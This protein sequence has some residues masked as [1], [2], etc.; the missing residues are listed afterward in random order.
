MQRHHTS[1]QV[2]QFVVDEIQLT[3]GSSDATTVTYDGDNVNILS[4]SRI[5][6]PGAFR[7]ETVVREVTAILRRP[8]LPGTRGL[9]DQQRVLN[10]KTSDFVFQMGGQKEDKKYK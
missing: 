3:S 1:P 10:V 8:G 2:I 4:K 7:K 9:I 5:D 6:G